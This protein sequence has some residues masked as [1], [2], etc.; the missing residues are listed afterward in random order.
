MVTLQTAN[1]AKQLFAGFTEK[2]MVEIQQLTKGS[3]NQLEKIE[4]MHKP[5]KKQRSDGGKLSVVISDT[6]KVL[7]RILD[8]EQL[9]N[10]NEGT[11]NVLYV[12]EQAQ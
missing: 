7:Y 10:I 5:G 3:I 9:F 11:S 12:R 6:K 8:F 4:K 2:V 1:Y